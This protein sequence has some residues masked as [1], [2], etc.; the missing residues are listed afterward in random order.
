MVEFQ[1]FQREIQNQ[2][3]AKKIYIQILFC[4]DDINT[5]YQI[6]NKENLMIELLCIYFTKN[7]YQKNLINDTIYI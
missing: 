6:Y 7:Y 5:K 4:F 2:D 1:K 3:F